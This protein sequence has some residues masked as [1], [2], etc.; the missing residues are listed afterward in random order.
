MGNKT[1]SPQNSPK[2]PP[3]PE[4]LAADA[5]AKAETT[6]G[7]AVC[8][9]SGGAPKPVFPVGEA[10]ACPNRDRVDG[11]FLVAVAPANG[12]QKEAAEGG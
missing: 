12:E 7:G 4:T 9:F 2:P 10:S 8:A 11:L 5:V 1:R 6:A 3:P